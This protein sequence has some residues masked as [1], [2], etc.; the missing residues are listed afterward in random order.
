MTSR[1]ATHQRDQERSVARGRLLLCAGIAA[2]L[3]GWTGAAA[4]AANGAD[5]SAAA[6]GATA[7]ANGGFADFD[8]NLLSGAGQNTT[9]LSRFE[10]G[11]PVLPGVY[12]TDIYLNGNWVGRRNVRFAT[13]HGQ[14]SAGACLDRDL[15]DQ[16]GLH[17]PQLSADI[18]AHL[19]DPAACVNIASLIPGATMTFD[20]GQL[21]LD[22]SVPQ[23]YMH[24]MPRGY[25]SPD[26]W[27]QGISA[28]LLNYNFNTYRSTNQGLSQ[29]T[30]YLG[31][32]G[33]INLGAWHLREIGSANWQSATSNARSRLQWQNIQTYLQRD[34]ASLRAQLT[35]GDSYTDGSVFDSYGLRGVQLGT[36]DRMLPQSLQGYAPVVRGVAQTNAHITVRQNGVVIYETTV[37]PGPFSLNDMFPNGYGGD[38]VVTVTEADGH[39][40]T[41]SVP[42]ASVAQLLRPGITRFDIAAGQLRDSSLQHKPEVVQGTLQ[43]GFTNL[44]TGY[45]GFVGSQ[46]YIAALAGSAINTRFG[47]IALD[48]THANTR[49]PGYASRSGQSMR[50][51]YSKI[52][53]STQTTLSVAA[54]RYSTGGFLSLTQAAQA[55]DYAREGIYP[56]SYTTT[57]TPVTINGVQQNTVL[58][59]AQ[60]AALSATNLTS[61]SALTVVGVQRQRNRFTLSLTQPLGE[62][63]GSLYAN[64]TAT[65]YWGQNNDDT[66]FQVGYNNHFHRI[67]YSFSATR[68][69]T[70]QGRY[71]NQYFVNVSVPLGDGQHAPT[72][73]FNATHNQ[74]NGSQDQAMLNGSLG[75]NNEFNYGVTATHSTQ[76]GSNAGSV[77]AGYRSP[78]AVFNASFGSGSGYSQA[79][80]SANG[81][82]IAHAG[83]VTFGQPMGD[84]V[85][86]V[87]VPNAY[88]A[89]V[90]NS[91]GAR[92][93]RGG[94]AIVPYLTPY[95]LNSIQID[96]KGL[97]LNVQLDSTSAQVAPYAGAVVMLKFKTESGRTLIA[98]TRMPDGSPLPFGAEVV[99]EKGTALGIVGQAGQILARGVGQ[100]GRLTAQ[101][102]D[103]GGTAHS[104]SFP[105]RLA[106][107]AKAGRASTFDEVDAVCVPANTPAR[108][109]S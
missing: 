74:G 73:S 69:V 5:A 2:A 79:S 36:D 8:R 101:W 86:L 49:I 11:N 42:Y 98:R 27:D 14:I 97:P 99:D 41:F 20:M 54:D 46:G 33:G 80:F 44:L 107:P 56:F 39:T 63:G 53:T 59:P 68:T 105:Y 43:H 96:P 102:Q 87:Y 103:D 76:D 15:L 17:P 31:L 18:A 77:N 25:V 16:L 47:A 32:N 82:V 10:H 9:D 72:V 52:I 70:P 83:G 106:A 12:N 94:Y 108:S 75:R 62:R 4:A 91:V 85:G 66:Q 71:S 22:T 30:S 104:C 29:T 26:Y 37:A 40:S 55:R 64:V 35:V 100:A 6:S 57:V 65:N 34:F 81:S 23:A 13:A 92:I 89:K 28:A 3:A 60:L 51:T 7:D 61:P 24:Q 95:S 50:L 21:R 88:G 84:T 90:N 78:Y 1:R 67:N 19:K 93:D 58:T 109:G 48:I 45:T 38:L